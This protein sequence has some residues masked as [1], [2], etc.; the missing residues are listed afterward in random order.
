MSHTSYIS[1]GNR[2]SLI[3]INDQFIDEL[4]SYTIKNAFNGLSDTEMSLKCFWKYYIE[5]NS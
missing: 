3:D 4:V 1:K 2:M 5:L